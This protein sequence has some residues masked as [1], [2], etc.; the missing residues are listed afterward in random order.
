[1]QR[2]F[3]LLERDRASLEEAARAEQVRGTAA[4]IEWDRV[5]QEVQKA[6][7]PQRSSW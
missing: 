7:T 5:M 2:V 6:E 3:K 4:L 1:M